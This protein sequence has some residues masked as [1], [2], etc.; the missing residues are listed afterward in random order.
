MEELFK[1]TEQPESYRGDARYLVTKAKSKPPGISLV[2]V[3]RQSNIQSV[4][5][6]VKFPISRFKGWVFHHCSHFDIHDKK[7]WTDF[8]SCQWR[9]DRVVVRC[10]RGAVWGGWTV[11]T[12]ATR[13][14]WVPNRTWRPPRSWR[15]RTKI[16]SADSPNCSRKSGPWRKRSIREKSLF[17]TPVNVHEFHLLNVL[18]AFLPVKLSNEH[19]AHPQRACW[20]GDRNDWL[21]CALLSSGEW[22]NC[23]WYDVTKLSPIRWEINF[24]LSWLHRWFTWKQVTWRW[25]MICWRNKQL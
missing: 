14:V 2:F 4:G 11:W 12:A 9:V 19:C 24:P 17:L 21:N 7:N 3:L 6:N 1:G 18:V 16:S 8:C 10:R 20:G 15:R 13:R 5:K 22:L 23:F 25:Q